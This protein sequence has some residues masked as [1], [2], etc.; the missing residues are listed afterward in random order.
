MPFSAGPCSRS[1]APYSATL[2]GVGFA[3]Y[4]AL[5]EFLGLALLSPQV[6]ANLDA[7]IADEAYATDAT[8]DSRVHGSHPPDPA[9]CRFASWD[10]WG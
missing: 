3:C 4:A 5:D 1:S 2:I 7:P 8:L 10:C 6:R 9:R